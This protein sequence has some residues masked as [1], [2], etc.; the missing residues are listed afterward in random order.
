[1]LSNIG[2]G[3]VVLV[4]ILSFLSIYTASLDLKTSSQFIKKKNL[5][6]KFISDDFHGFKFLY[7]SNWFY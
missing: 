7:F 3:L 2:I 4:L 1:M 6:I 5:S